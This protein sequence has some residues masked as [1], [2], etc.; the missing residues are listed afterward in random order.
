MR[1][2]LVVAMLGIALAACAGRD[3]QPIATVQPQ[4]QTASCTQLT[5]EIQ[6]NNI[7]VQELA[8][9]QGVKVAQNVAA[10]VVGLVLWPVWFGMDFKGAAGKD[11]AALQARQQYLTTL[12]TEKCA[13]KPEPEPTRRSKP[14]PPIAQAP[15]V[16]AETR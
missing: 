3:P 9:E 1:R 11:V 7:K 4:D 16:G 15:T 5:A 12:A 6:A 8:D 14:K 2:G 13:P 10:G